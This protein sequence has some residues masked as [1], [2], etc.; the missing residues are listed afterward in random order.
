MIGYYGD[1]TKDEAGVITKTLDLVQEN[2]CSIRVVK[3][4]KTINFIIVVQLI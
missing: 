1:D 4:T 3:L 2:V